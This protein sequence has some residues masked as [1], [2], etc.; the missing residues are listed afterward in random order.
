MN[1]G[2]AIAST[3]V[4]GIPDVVKD[5]Y[6]GALCNSNNPTDLCAAMHKAIS[7][8]VVFG[9]HNKEYVRLFDIKNTC[10]QY[11]VFFKEITEE[12]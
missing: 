10:S 2:L 5:N 3:S 7:N 4:G 12:K 1:A 8:A 6:N 9:E 11:L